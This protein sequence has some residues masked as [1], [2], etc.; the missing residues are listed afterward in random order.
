MKKSMGALI[1]AIMIAITTLTLVKLPKEQS[2]NAQG[3]SQAKNV[4]L[5]IGDG[6][7]MEG[8]T[9]SRNTKG[10]SLAMDEIAVG[11]VMTSWASGPIT[12]SAPGGTAYSAGQKTYNKYI[13]TST[14]DAPLATILEGAENKGKAT[15]LIATS[16]IT[17]ATPA[18][19]AA[20][21]DNRKNYNQ[22]L[23]QEINGNLEVLL[24]G[25][26]NTSWGY[27]SDVEET[28]FQDYYKNRVQ[29]IKDE[30]YQYVTTK[31]EMEKADGTKL[32]G[33][34]ADGDLKY[35]Y[36]RIAD[37]D[38]VQPSLSEMTNKAIDVLNKD[39]DGFFLMVE[40]SKIDW[41]AHANNTAGIVSEVLAFDEAV[42]SA[43][44]FA[45]KDG[46]TVVVVTTD[47]GNSGITIGS[48]YYNTNVG[49]YDKATYKDSI[50]KLKDA[51]ITEE[52][53]DT[54]AS[55]KSD[56][57]I[58]TLAKEYYNFDLTDEELNLV[59]GFDKNG[60]AIQGR[61][62]GIREVV[63]RRCGI[64]YTTGG[65]TSEQVYLGV[66]SPEQVES[67]DGVIDNTEVNKYMQRV[68][69]GSE[70]LNDYTKEIYQDGAEKLK[71][72]E[73]TK[74]TVDETIKYAPKAI[75]ERD[76]KKIEL[77][78]YTNKYTLNGEAKELKT[79]V[80]YIKGKFYVSNEL[81]QIVSSLTEGGV[82]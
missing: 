19:F 38:E 1:A 34:F 11:T 55:K 75:I 14:S 52:R 74:V 64:G 6:M 24:G 47:H 43:V 58:K 70:I 13:G 69:F 73:G 68:L 27:T 21:T 62:K 40:G 7:S 25:G 12:D 53:F 80:P 20:H 36:D 67:I 35:D 5:L 46:N 28:A 30:G 78:L 82:N 50:D 65:H 37:K 44:D 15:G 66:Y 31:S 18:D 16:E 48:N 59:K 63:A 23:R 3:K 22:I 33:A 45:K 39:D 29:E 72:I 32:W 49:S 57:E 56:D 17:H 42:K 8:V 2:V 71:A 9:L 54:L 60:V 81:L 10:Q 79:V 77:E 4:I 41:A 61:Q 76:G 26:F 51:K